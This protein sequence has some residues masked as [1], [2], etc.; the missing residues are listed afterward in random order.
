MLWVVHA[1]CRVLASPA[2][3]SIKS[4]SPT[5][6]RHRA[7]RTAAVSVPRMVGGE[8][9]TRRVWALLPAGTREI[10]GRQLAPTDLQTLLLSVVRERAV[11]VTLAELVRRW[12]DDRFV[13]PS[14]SDPR[15]L[16]Q[17]EAHVWSVIPTEFAGLELSPV[18]PLGTCSAVAEVSKD[19][20]L[21]TVRRS[22]V[23]SDSTNA[24]A[25][26]AALRRRSSA[27][28]RGVHLAACHRQLRAQNFGGGRSAHFRLFTLVS[29]APKS[30]SG[31][32]E[33][34]LQLRHV[35]CWVHVVRAVLPEARIR[36]ELT[37][38]DSVLREGIIRAVLPEF[39]GDPFIAV[40][41]HGTRQRGRVTARSEPC[42][43]SRRAMTEN[44]SWETAALPTGPRS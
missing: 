21:A 26:E 37:A 13:R 34:D 1:V 20:V 9:A 2:P 38:W 17:L 4:R 19:R 12:Q 8:A 23:V 14:D 33:T 27:G 24:L 10:L 30:G 39:D 18:V 16:S 35:R 28:R 32:Q 44:S 22:E 43:S 36:V 6:G 11:S 5:G 40:V 42:G 7:L 3:V 15:W 41:E 25:V 31:M 29:S